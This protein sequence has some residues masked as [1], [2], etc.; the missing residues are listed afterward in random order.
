MPQPPS[1]NMA[2]VMPNDH[3]DDDVWD[4]ILD[5]ALGMTVDRHDHTTGKGVPIP[6]QA[7]KI[8]ADV[9][10]S[11]GGSSYALTDLRAIDFSPQPAAGMTALAG[12]IFVSDG[13][14]GLAAG[15]L[16]WRTVLGANV[17]LTSGNALNVAAFTGGIG[18]DYSAVGALEI[19]DDATDSY[20]FQQQVGASVRQYARM[21]SA[22]VDL[23]EYKANPA[24]G[25]PTQR[26]RL[27][28]PAALAASYALTFPAALPP[29]NQ[30]V[31]I[32]ATGAVTTGTSMALAA[33]ANLTLTG[34]GT[35]RHGSKTINKAIQAFE[36]VNGGGGS[37]NTTTNQPGVSLANNTIVY[38]PLPIMPTH[39][40]LLSV[41]V[42][43]A[44]AADATACTCKLFA[45][46]TATPA[47]TGF[48]DL[49]TLLTTGGTSISTAGGLMLLPSGSETFWVQISN[50]ATTPK[51]LA[52]TVNYDVP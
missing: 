22:D 51:I 4:T 33:N 11:S 30:A 43:F 14:S 19:F 27:A 6:G 20:W 13:T 12:A 24:T 34:T 44:S 31:A 26:V 10:W 18:G 37:V 5:T 23:Y 15:E 49:S 36:A 21:R 52:M 45:T 17:K 9:S 25:V 3:D 28:S 46:S 29:A 40:R 38:F 16:Y 8:T 41:S 1:P 42:W 47:G 35:Y 32:D 39:Y 2:I 50:S 48:T 7:L